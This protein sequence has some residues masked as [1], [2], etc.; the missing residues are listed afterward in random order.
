M[1][2]TF[3]KAGLVA[4]VI[5]CLVGGSGFAQADEFNWS[6]FYAGVEGG[7]ARGASG[8]VAHKGFFDPEFDFADPNNDPKGSATFAAGV[9]GGHVGVRHQSGGLVFGVEGAWDWARLGG[10][11]LDPY[12]TETPPHEFGV[13]ISSIGTLNAQV[14]VAN[15]RWLAYATGGLA[16]ANVAVSERG[17]CFENNEPVPD[18]GYM[19]QGDERRM[20]W[21]AGVGLSHAIGN[22]LIAGIEYQ[23]IDLGAFDGKANCEGGGCYVLVGV[24]P[25]IDVVKARLSLKLGN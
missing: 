3:E 12:S 14:G 23:H 21:N 20:G 2:R 9:L 16:V 18:C 15:D 7:A 4:A 13:A 17:Q 1:R 11:V 22:S 25:T 5:G 8:H 19:N 24:E 6:G 10:S